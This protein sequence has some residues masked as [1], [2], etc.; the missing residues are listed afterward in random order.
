MKLGVR[1]TG[2]FNGIRSQAI[3]HFGSVVH[4]TFT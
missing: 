4:K 3:L 2:K 1:D